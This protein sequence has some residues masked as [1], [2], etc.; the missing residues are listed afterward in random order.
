MFLPN[1]VQEEAQ[2]AEWERLAAADAQAAQERRARMEQTRQDLV[3]SN[4]CAAPVLQGTKPCE[5]AA[6]F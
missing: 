4:K 6:A 2:R 5:T 3:A 1:L